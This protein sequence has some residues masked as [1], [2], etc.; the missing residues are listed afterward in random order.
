[1]G[2]VH[3]LVTCMFASHFGEM[4]NKHV[5]ASTR[6]YYMYP[7]GWLDQGVECLEIVEESGNAHL[8]LYL[9]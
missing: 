5:L 4:V 7:W 6:I 9:C 3:S 1:M 8:I 2:H